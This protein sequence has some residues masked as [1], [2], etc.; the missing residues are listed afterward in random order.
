MFAAHKVFRR[1]G[2]GEGNYWGWQRG[3]SALRAANGLSRA[4]LGGGGGGQRRRACEY[5]DGAADDEEHV[6]AV[7]AVGV[8]NLQAQIMMRTLRGAIEQIMFRN[9]VSLVWHITTRNLRQQ[10]R[11]TNGRR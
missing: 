9:S 3:G 1:G 5:A 4:R 6:A 10:T 8:E 11:T 2:R 7:L